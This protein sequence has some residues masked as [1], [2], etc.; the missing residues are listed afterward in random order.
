MKILTAGPT[1]IDPRVLQAMA[2]SQF[3][4]DLDPAYADFHW[5]VTRKVSDF[6]N[7]DAQTIFMTGEAMLAL[8][9]SVCS[10]MEAGERVLV[11]SNGVFGK[12]FED[13]VQFFGGEAVVFEGDPQHGFDTDALKTFLENDHDFALA[14]MVHCETP[15]GV[16]NDIGRICQLLYRYGILSIVDGV[17]S[18]AAEKIFFDDSKIDIFIGGSQKCLSGPT[19]LSLVTIS[20]RAKNKIDGRSLPVPSYYMNLKM[21]YDT[22]A[23]ALFPYTMS[24]NLVQAMNVALD[25]AK[26]EDFIT[27]HAI[28]AS[29]TREIFT[30][31]GYDLFAKDHYAQSVTAIRN[32]EGISSQEILDEL[33]KQNIIISK[34]LGPWRESLFRI[35]H[36]GHNISYDRFLEL[37]QA[38]DKTFITLGVKDKG[39]LADAFVK[40]MPMDVK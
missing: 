33:A 9:A 19:G 27:R 37:Y 16:S 34:G 28:Y 21:Y 25:I 10:L 18:L 38:I 24:E 12:C 23:P 36:M 1:S 5:A 32:P 35:G 2:G 14:T 17:S 11:L 40:S 3:N 20:Q 26:E 8:E 6:L 22:P 4:P 15:T 7:T 29:N 39:S 31:C 13:Y 30:E